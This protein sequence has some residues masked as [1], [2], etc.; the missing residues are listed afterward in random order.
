MPTPA[1]PLRRVVYSPV[2]E[3][4]EPVRVGPT[5]RRKKGRMLEGLAD[6]L[7]RTEPWAWSSLALPWP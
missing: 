7:N 4:G 3:T 2:P 1:T 5:P 6:G